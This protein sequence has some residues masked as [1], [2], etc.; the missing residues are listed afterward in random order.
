MTM[1]ASSV[2]LTYVDET[3]AALLRVCIRDADHRNEFDV[4]RHLWAVSDR[5]KLPLP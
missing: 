1:S 4:E 5:E 3:T 2:L